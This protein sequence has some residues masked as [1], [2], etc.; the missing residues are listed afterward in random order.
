M[1]RYRDFK[2][3]IPKEKKQDDVVIQR[4]R[5]PAPTPPTTDSFSLFLSSVGNAAVVNFFENLQIQA[6][7]KTS[8]PGDFHERQADKIAEQ[9]VNNQEGSPVTELK[10][11]KVQGKGATGGTVST[12]IETKIKQ[13]H[14]KGNALNRPLRNFF[15]PRLGVDL[16]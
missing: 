2:E 7:L 8:T 11:D 16:E 15:E 14:G 5:D 13:L 3:R 6:K 10:I 4:K 12:G 1:E 9:I